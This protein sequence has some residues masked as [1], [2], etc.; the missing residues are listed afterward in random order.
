M[1]P[2]DWRE[3][4]RRRYNTGLI[5]AG[6]GAFVLCI[7]VGEVFSDALWDVEFT[8]FTMA[9]QAAGYLIYMALANCCYSLGSRLEYWL[10]PRKP[11]LYRSIAYTLAR[12]RWRNS[13]NC[14][15]R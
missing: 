1:S 13:M 15:L 12:G 9:A 3:A 5:V 11:H 10:N 7:V 8:V 6:A 2:L 14:F 4:Q